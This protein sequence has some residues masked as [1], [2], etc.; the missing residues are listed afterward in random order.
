MPPSV[1]H[2]TNAAVAQGNEPVGHALEDTTRAVRVSGAVL[3]EE[4][5]GR[6]GQS[7]TEDAQR[8]EV[9]ADPLIPHHAEPVA[10]P[11]ECGGG[12]SEKPSP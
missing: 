7:V 2:G 11:A 9:D 12:M 4:R 10:R 8:T 6:P 3:I 1:G 5:G